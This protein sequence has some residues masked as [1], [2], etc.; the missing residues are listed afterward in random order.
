MTN[1]T[2]FDE[3]LAAET[4]FRN[5]DALLTA[6]GNYRPTLDI[7]IPARLE[8]ADAYDAA[9]IERGDLRRAFRTGTPA[10]QKENQLNRGRRANETINGNNLN[11]VHAEALQLNIE[12]DL[13]H[14][15]LIMTRSEIADEIETLERDLRQFKRD[16]RKFG[17]DPLGA[18][19]IIEKNLEGMRRLLQRAPFESAAQIGKT[20]KQ[21]AKD[22]IAE[23]RKT[24]PQNH[25]THRGVDVVAYDAKGDRVGDPEFLEVHK[26]TGAQ[27]K[28][29]FQHLMRYDADKI[30]GISIQGGID[31]HDSFA[32][33]MAD[34]RDGGWSDYEPMTNEWSL[35]IDDLNLFK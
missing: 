30:V 25:H 17:K 21:L 8:L 13:D 9:M 23:S 26:I 27:L 3:L 12:F 7:S 20:A 1:T 34:H 22:C 35:D 11:R 19:A 6:R 28:A 2:R 4:C 32:E 18:I 33:Y 29:A 10:Q 16:A 24:L 15:E 14:C 5:F 31:T